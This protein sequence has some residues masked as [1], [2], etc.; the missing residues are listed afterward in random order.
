MIRITS[1]VQLT[2]VPFL[3][4]IEQLAVVH[5]A[6][7]QLTLDR[8]NERRP[9]EQSAAQL[10]QAL[11]NLGHRVDLRMQLEHGHVLFA[12]ALLRLHQTRGA[13]DANDQTAYD[14]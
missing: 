7:S 1:F 3:I 9:L 2:H 8:R 6:H 11:L 12:G 4:V 5:G 13:I 10:L 14:G